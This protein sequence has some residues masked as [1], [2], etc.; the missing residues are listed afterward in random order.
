MNFSSDIENQSPAAIAAFQNQKLAEAIQY[1]AEYSPFY[2]K[3]FTAHGITPSSITSREALQNIPPTTKDDLQQFN[4]DFLCV[5]RT[6]ITEYTSTSGTLGKPVTVALTANDLQRLAYN[7]S[8][9]FTCAGVKSTDVVQLMLTLDKQFMA[10]LAY[11]EG[12]RKLGAAAVRIGPGVPALQW[13]TIFNL[14]STVLV[15][16]AS[17]IVKLVEYARQNGIDYKSSSVR[18]IICIGENIRTENL[19]LNVLG[20]RIKDLWNVTLISTYASTEM[21]T[22]FTECDHGKGGH[23]RPELVIVELLNEANQ[24]VAGGEAGEVTITTL[25]VEAMPLIRYKTGDMAR[26]FTEPCS[27]GRTTMRI[28]PLIGRKQQMIKLKGTT[29]YP[30]ALFDVLQH[31]QGVIDYIVEAFTN[32]TGVDE[33][34]VLVASQDTE[35]TRAEL[36]NNFKAAL[37]VI[38]EITFIGSD[39]IEKLQFAG[40]S[41]KIRRFIDN[42]Q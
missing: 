25:G 16:V 3:H 4:W 39:E 41:R 33:V 18:T 22:A 28:S 2:K 10:G 6:A 14:K 36:A 9:S 15:G 13:Q 20:K 29:L 11:H 32:E 19:E 7:E 40:G 8:V 37:R 12:V 21:Q 5:P 24:P 34:K 42:R 30:Q 27:C 35:A 1:A 23:H 31:T 38:P 26:L 17:F